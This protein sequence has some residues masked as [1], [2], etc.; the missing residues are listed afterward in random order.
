MGW[1]PSATATLGLE[2]MPY[3]ESVVPLT[4]TTDCV[5]WLVD[6]T[7][8]ETIDEIYVPHT[9]TGPS[10]GY[11][12][13][14]VD[15]YDLSD[16]GAGDTPTTTRYSPNQDVSIGNLY[17]PAP[18]SWGSTLS[19]GSGYTKIDDG[20]AHNDSDWLA[21]PGGSHLRMAFNTAGFTGRPTSVTFDV[22]VFGYYGQNGKLHVELYNG[23][24]YVQRLGTITPPA[25][26]ADWPSGFRTY[27]I[28]PFTTNPLTGLPWTTSDITSFD[29]ASNL[30]VQLTGP[31]SST[32]VSWL[33]MIVESGADKRVATASTA[34]QTSPPWGTQTGLVATFASNWSKASGTD[35]LLVAR[36]IDDPAGAAQALIPQPIYLDG[37]AAA[38]HGQGVLYSSTIESSGLLSSIGTPHATRTVG[39]W[40]GRTDNAMS[41]D[42]QPFYD[43]GFTPV[44]TATAGTGPSQYFGGAAAVAYKKVRCVVA[45]DPDAMP[46]AGMTVQCYRLSDNVQFGGT[47]TLTVADLT[48]PEKA[49]LLGTLD[50]RSLYLATIDLN[51]SATLATATSY[52][53]A[54]FSSAAAATPWYLVYLSA[55]ATHALTGNATYEGTTYQAYI[56]STGVVSADIPA[57]LST[58][59]SAPSSITVTKTTATINGA[60]VDYA[61]IEWVN[62][63]TLGA[64]FLRWD[65][66]RSEDGGTTW[67][68]IATISTEATVEL[69]DYESAR[70][71]AVKYR[72]RQ[73]RTDLASS[74]WTTQSGTITPASYPNAWA[75]FTTNAAPDLTVGYTPHGTDL[76]PEFLSADEVEFV[77]LHDED[78]QASFAPLEERGVRMAFRLQ[79][80]TSSSTPSGGHGV[81]VFDA[82]RAV[83]RASGSLCLHTADGERFFG[84]LQVHRGPRDFATGWYFA[85]VAFTQ[86]T[87]SASVVAL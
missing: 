25:D 19:S 43:I 76:I 14:I 68:R 24:T 2:W 58:A 44:S 30:L 82:I 83:A 59:P 77:P 74:D 32:A 62:G 72:V 79:I 46:D 29:T 27:R 34:V 3:V 80:H 36:R 41:A 53:L 45:V 11:G 5:A 55:Y 6:S 64:A 84:T 12:K 69:D 37:S 87:G 22:R 4:T 39:F 65:V 42:S 10:S 75:V 70:N 13:L 85:E 48:D 1:N 35:Y 52:Y 67:S 20:S 8:T 9:W 15:V 86:T 73:V 60:T 51:S 18:G 56:A 40:L 17:A 78:Y 47:A 7:V 23:S 71:V 33:S 81:R 16:T 54:W 28:G 63:G 61:A 49:T 21:F 26:G 38:P 57:T 66:D 31:V 50:G